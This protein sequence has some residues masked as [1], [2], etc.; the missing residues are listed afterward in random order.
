MRDVRDLKP[1]GSAHC[2]QYNTEARFYIDASG[3]KRD[4]VVRYENGG[5]QGAP[6][7]A[8]GI[9][10]TWTEQDITDLLLWPMKEP[11]A[12]YPAWEVSARVHGSPTLFRW[13]AGEKPGA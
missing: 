11:D 3:S 10:D 7:F 8:T 13:W 4:L 6:E 9:P 2:T 5:Y 12:P 1:L